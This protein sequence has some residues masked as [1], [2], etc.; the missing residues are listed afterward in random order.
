MQI[1]KDKFVDILQARKEFKELQG[2]S[3]NKHKVISAF[4]KKVLKFVQD[5]N[6]EHFYIPHDS[7]ISKPAQLYIPKEYVSIFLKDK[8]ARYCGIPSQYDLLTINTTG[9]SFNETLKELSITYSCFRQR[10]KYSGWSF[11]RAITTPHKDLQETEYRNKIKR[12]LD[13]FMIRKRKMKYRQ[14]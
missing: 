13:R 7:N 5:N 14:F 11:A 12:E 9:K 3:D 8:E 1:D 6:I 2:T 10:I 4:K